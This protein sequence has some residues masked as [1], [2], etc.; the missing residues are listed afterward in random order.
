MS[1]KSFKRMIQFTIITHLLINL[2][3]D[4]RQFFNLIFQMVLLWYSSDYNMIFFILFLVHYWW[5]RRFSQMLSLHRRNLSPYW[6]LKI[7]ILL[8][9]YV[10]FLF[11]CFLFLWFKKYKFY[12]VHLVCFTFC[13]V[14]HEETWLFIIFTWIY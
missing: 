11:K 4:H 2:K 6:S 14:E 8:S 1:F 5:S 3:N 10:L 12:F 7:I 9:C 13:F